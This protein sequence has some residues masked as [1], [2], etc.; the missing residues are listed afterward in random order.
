M[1][2]VSVETLFQIKRIDE[3]MMQVTVEKRSKEWLYIGHPNILRDRRGKPQRRL[4]GV[5][6]EMGRKP[7]EIWHLGNHMVI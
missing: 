7:A 2:V 1:E 3:V 5:T 6:R 4:R